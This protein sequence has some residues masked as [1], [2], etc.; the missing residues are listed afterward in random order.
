ML[1]TVTIYYAGDL[2]LQQS[3]NC[4]KVT[5]LV[6]SLVSVFVVLLVIVFIIGF[7]CGHCFIGRKFSKSESPKSREA[8]LPLYEDVRVLPS[9]MQPQEEHGQCLELNENVAYGSSH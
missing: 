1:N 4:D 9:A 8:P 2:T 7:I 6:T 5:V 3:D